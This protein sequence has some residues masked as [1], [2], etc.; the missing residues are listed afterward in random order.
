MHSSIAIS[1]G[2]GD[3]AG[4]WEPSAVS[5]ICFS[6]SISLESVDMLLETKGGPDNRQLWFRLVD[7]KRVHDY[8]PF[9]QTDIAKHF[10]KA[11]E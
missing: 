11:L 3:Q 9:V 8:K 1:I 10:Q 5:E 6:P 2:T 4:W 7:H